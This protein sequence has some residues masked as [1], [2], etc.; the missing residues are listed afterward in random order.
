MDWSG[1]TE[2]LPDDE[3]WNGR[4]SEICNG[5]QEQSE[6]ER[7]HSEMSISE[8]WDYVQKRVLEM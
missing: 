3:A 1:E 6:H 5:G 4:C 2:E 8:F 7:T